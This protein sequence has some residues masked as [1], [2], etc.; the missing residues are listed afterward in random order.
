MKSRRNSGCIPIWTGKA[1]KLISWMGSLFQSVSGLA[2]Y[3]H[4]SS[5][6]DMQGS[7][8]KGT[9]TQ[10][11]L[12]FIS[13]CCH[14][15]LVSLSKFCSLTGAVILQLCSALLFWRVCNCA[16]IQLAGLVC[17]VIRAQVLPLR[18][19]GYVSSQ[20]TFFRSSR[21][22]VSHHKTAC[23]NMVQQKASSNLPS[24]NMQALNHIMPQ[25]R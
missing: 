12:N 9:W 24:S 3:L 21:I 7:R 8:G 20:G 25:W 5:G 19:A 22:S 18:P 1:R 23:R 15:I 10:I 2:E 16:L 6:D 11:C 14:C 4:H 13:C 17:R